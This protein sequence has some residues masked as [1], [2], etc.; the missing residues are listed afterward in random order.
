MTPSARYAVPLSLAMCILTG[1]IASV[2]DE[3]LRERVR[4]SRPAWESYQEDIKSQVGAAPVAE[5]QGAL[6]RVVCQRNTV[7]LTFQIQGPWAGRGTAIPVLVR[8]PFGGIHG[9]LSVQ[10]DQGAVTYLFELPEAASA[11]PFPWIEVK[12]PHQE[13]RIVLSERGTWTRA[14]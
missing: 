14:E 10:N 1:C 7:R 8:E 2:D 3:E 13:K 12:F 6:Q 11:T 4:T 5:W 9:S